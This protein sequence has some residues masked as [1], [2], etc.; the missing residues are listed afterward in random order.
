MTQ[1]RTRLAP[2]P[3]GYLHWGNAANLLLTAQWAQA[4]GAEVYLRIDD[5]DP[6]RTRDIYIEDILKV[7][8]ALKID[9]I[10]PGSL[11]EFKKDYSLHA[12]FDQAWSAMA[13]L[14]AENKAFP[15]TCSHGHLKAR[16]AQ[17]KYDGYCLQYPKVYR[18]GQTTLR[19]IFAPQP[20][21]WRKNQL[22]F[23]HLI[24]TLWDE[25]M[26]MTHLIR[27]AD[28]RPSSQIHRKLAVQLG[29]T[30]FDKVQIYHHP[31]WEVAG[32]KLSKSSIRQGQS[33]LK[34]VGFVRK[35]KQKVSQWYGA[36]EVGGNFVRH[37]IS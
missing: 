15:C 31:L 23:Y 11:A 25:K 29:W 28:L 35:I 36:L 10:G 19:A 9:Y 1:L 32:Q 18:P 6:Q 5:F 13:H 27:G 34:E 16:G 21:L 24:S 33:L 2:T 14:L 7:I 26:A 4:Q 12:Y 3:N 22:P 17:E 8:E 30:H 37:D 20:I